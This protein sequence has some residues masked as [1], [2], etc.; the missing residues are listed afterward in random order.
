MHSQ[1][2]RI[3]PERRVAHAVSLAGGPLVV[4]LHASARPPALAAADL[5]RAR[6]AALDWA[7]GRPI[8][9]GGDLNLRGDVQVAGFERL[10]SRDVDHLFALGLTRRGKPDVL[11]RG[12]LSDHPP[13]AVDLASA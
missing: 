11:D 7:G 2:L 1:S 13:L 4:N 3:L 12:H 5:E 9:L 10:A 8:V 6:S